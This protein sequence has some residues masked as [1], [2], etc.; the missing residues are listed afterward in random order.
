MSTK[1]GER[2]QA[3]GGFRLAPL[4]GL[5]AAGLLVVWV[6][7]A[8]GPVALGAGD[9]LAALLGRA[10]A[11]T[12]TIVL[13]IRLPR[14]L[15]ALAIGAGLGCA[16]AA[17]QGYLRNPLAEPA[18]L[19]ASNAAA[20]GAVIAIYYG[21]SAAV[22]LALPLLACGFAL[23]AMALLLLLTR[24]SRGSLGLILSGIALSSVFGALISLLLNLS[25]NPFAAMEIAFWLLGSLDD[26]SFTHVALALPPILA[27]LALLLWDRRAFDALSLGEETA[28]SLGFDLAR[29]R[30]RVIGGVALAVGASVAVA[31]SIGFL[32]LVVPHMARLWLGAR[33]SRLLLPSAALGAV[34]LACADSL[35]R[36]FPS[37]NELKLGVVTALVGAPFLIH[38][39]HAMHRTG[40]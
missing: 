11:L 20:L 17:L 4:A 26:R 21:L 27:G 40:R 24:G 19:G 16:G 25:P 35:V 10:D 36:V 6:S 2:P 32:G 39:L 5:A 18:L 23:G 3:R 37:T 9:V 30:V 34:L 7:L 14:L 8:T 13:E 12:N 1:A 38:L 29:V 15:L 31:G 33:P 28:Q 22:P